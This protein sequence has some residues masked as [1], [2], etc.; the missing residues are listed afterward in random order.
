MNPKPKDIFDGIYLGDTGFIKQKI[1]EGVDLK[2]MKGGHTVLTAAFNWQWYGR[3]GESSTPEELNKF[4]KKTFE[5]VKI[6][7]ENGAEINDL[8]NTPFL[9]RTPLIYA[10]YHDMNDVAK[11]LLENGADA[12]LKD[13]ERG[14]TPIFYTCDKEQV[15]LLL[16]YGA[17]INAQDN[18]GETVLLDSVK[19]NRDEDYIS[20][21]LE[22]DADPKIKK[23]GRAHV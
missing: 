13:N 7:I 17:D 10:I 16:E 8:S 23:I 20:F 12:N 19:N 1:N 4:H 9:S 22:K 21:L 2:K 18:F 11:Y 15:D 3:R 5:M 14:R 6:L